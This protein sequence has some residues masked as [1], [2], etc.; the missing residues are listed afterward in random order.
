MNVEV[1]IPEVVDEKVENYIIFSLDN[2]ATKEAYFYQWCQSNGISCKIVH[3]FFEGTYESSFIINKKH[4][5]K[6]LEDKWLSNQKSVLVLGELDKGQRKAELYDIKSGE[7]IRQGFFK[8]TTK[9]HALKQTAWTYDPSQGFGG[10]YFI[11][12]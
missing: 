9:E 11:V 8:P 5:G 6:L 2:D 1:L 3:G 4:M 12:E 7:Y 10:Q